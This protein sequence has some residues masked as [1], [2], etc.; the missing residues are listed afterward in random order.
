MMKIYG[1]VVLVVAM[2]GMTSGYLP[3]F[4]PKLDI[5]VSMHKWINEGV[6][7]IPVVALP[8][9]IQGRQ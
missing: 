3:S 9:G 2:F 7:Y 6:R 1:A 4:I 8:P 5:S